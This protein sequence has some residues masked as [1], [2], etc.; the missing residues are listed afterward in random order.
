MPARERGSTTAQHRFGVFHHTAFGVL[1]G[2]YGVC[3]AVWSKSKSRG[4]G[5]PSG[6]G[7][8]IQCRHTAKKARKKVWQAV[9]PAVLGGQPGPGVSLSMLPFH[10]SEKYDSN[11][12]RKIVADETKQGPTDHV[13]GRRTREQERPLLI[14]SPQPLLRVFRT[15]VAYSSG[16]HAQA[17]SGDQHTTRAKG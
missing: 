6:Q 12:A 17:A 7:A 1:G 4:V 13:S 11:R 16:R 9:T 2:P 5:A 8:C 10:E 14:Y 3:F 15:T